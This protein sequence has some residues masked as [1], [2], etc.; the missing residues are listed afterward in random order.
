MLAEERLRLGRE[1]DDEGHVAGGLTLVAEVTER[2]G[3]LRAARRLYEEALAVDRRPGN[4]ER[5]IPHLLNYAALLIR[6]GELEAADD[7]TAEAAGVARVRGADRMIAA[8]AENAA[9][10]ALLRDRPERALDLLQETLR[11]RGPEE[12]GLIWTALELTGIALIG[13]ERHEQGVRFLGLARRIRAD[14][15]D[16]LDSTFTALHERAVGRARSALGARTFA[17]AHGRGERLSPTVA[18]AELS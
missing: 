13:D 15:G 8:A 7:A 1:L 5:L 4:D 2:R 3:D 18:I 17:R 10:I 12:S 9:V 11:R 6:S 16:E 14:R